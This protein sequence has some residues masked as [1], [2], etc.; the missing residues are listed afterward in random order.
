MLHIEDAIQFI[1]VNKKI[2]NLKIHPRFKQII[3]KLNYSI[4]IHN[5]NPTDIE[6]SEIDGK[7]KKITKKQTEENT[8]LLTQVLEDGIWQLETKFN[9]SNSA[10]AGI[11][12]VQDSY[13]IPA[14]T[15]PTI[16]PHIQ[17]MAVFVGNGWTTSMICYKGI[18]TFEISG[19]GD[20]QILKLEFDSK[21]ATLFL[22]VDNIQQELYIC[23]IKEK[24][25]FIIYM[26]YTG[27]QCTIQSLKK[28]SAPTSSHVDNEK[29]VEW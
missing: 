13:K 8:I 19:F 12:I 5:P 28:L 23:G 7:M 24:L 26:Y 18:G 27:S 16:N 20:N 15:N 11:G 14:D 1:E 10:D 21:K 4:A 22:F 2:L 17:N 25:R 29:S 9:N 3:E 6:L